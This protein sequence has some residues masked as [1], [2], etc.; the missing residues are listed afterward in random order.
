MIE[1]VVLKD[2]LMT[3]QE[4]RELLL[5]PTGLCCESL[6][7]PIGIECPGA[8]GIECPQPRLSWT[9]PNTP[10]GTAQTAYHIRVAGAPETLADGQGELWDSGWIE[11]TEATNVLYAGAPLRSLARC[12]WQVRIRDGRGAI[13]AWSEPSSWTMGIVALGDWQARWI[14]A[15]PGVPHTVARY[16]RNGRREEAQP[17]A[18]GD[19]TAADDCAAVYLRREIRCTQAVRRATLVVCGLGYGEF[20]IDGHKVGDHV[21]DPTFSDYNKRV[22]Y[23]VH[24]VTERFTPGS[25]ALAAILGNGFYNLVTPNLFQTEKAPWKT[26]P[27][28]LVQIVLEYADGSTATIITDSAWRQAGGPIVF[29]CVIGGETI[30][31]RRA[32]PGWLQPGF[33][34]TDWVP[35]LQVQAP[36]GRLAADL[37]PPMRVVERLAPLRITE[38]Q[39]G[40]YVVDFGRN[41]V[42]WV[43]LTTSGAAGAR[44][45]LDHN[46]HL[47]PQGTLDTAC[48]TSHTFGR[49]QH[50][51]CILA[52]SCRETFEPRF[53][54]HAFRYVEIRG[55]AQAPAAHDLVACRL[56]TDLAYTGSFRS[57]N[58]RLNF[59]HDAA[60]RTLADCTF[61]MPAA[62]AVREK[63][64]WNG[65]NTFCRDAYLY[66][67]DAHAL[68]RKNAL[69]NL[70]A[71]APNGQIPPIA[72]TNGWGYLDDEGQAEF[73]DDPWWGGS[74]AFGVQGVN[75][76]YGDL[77]LMVNAYEGC[78]RYVD[79]LTSTAIDGCLRWSLGDWCDLTYKW[80]EGPGLTPVALTS[81]ACYFALAKLTAHDAELLGKREDAATYSAL[82]DQIK[83]AFVRRFLSPHGARSLPP[84]SQTG[85]SLPLYLGLVPAEQEATMLAQLLASLDHAQGHLTTGFVGLMPTLYHLCATGHTDA[86][87]A[88]VTAP[89][90]S[91]WFWM[92]DGPDCTLAETI[93]PQMAPMHHH[94]FS[95]CIAGWLYR[96]LGGIRPDLARSES[97][98]AVPAA[99]F[100]IAP[101]LPADL[102]WVET[103]WCSPR[104][105]I[106]SNWYRR[107][108]GLRFE[109]EIPGNTLARVELPTPDAAAIQENG[110]PL[111]EA[112]GV[113]VVSEADGKVALLVGAGRYVFVVPKHRGIL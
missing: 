110:V 6:R 55:L 103:A 101:C 68:Y 44:I 69:D 20:F 26:P 96:C 35:A 54:Y 47:T 46:E 91:G 76:F 25:H 87:Y 109:I 74:L 31:A 57:A 5:S 92:L 19:C 34:D 88:A 86:A 43:C 58:D 104:G 93:F 89:E 39:P 77:P 18:A 97:H 108:D 30:D 21:L 63:I 14:A 36:L 15:R 84:G 94:Q 80:P 28:L 38:P 53:T 33:D 52:G 13:S 79:Y 23:R 4:P 45:T 105:L 67:F 2:P 70:D 98:A 50:Q 37:L 85:L 3:S 73:C 10:R 7:N 32:Q 24:D 78:R 22:Y 81:T 95:A 51:E 56:H 64:G 66:L 1:D 61:G 40:V 29:N 65:D 60:R 113:R 82:A 9:V 49:Y 59:L 100:V 62:E 12:F 107:E 8:L 11:S 83:A 102:A 41:L 111:A 16:F 106:V 72:P 42:G 99:D 71:Q 75:D 27:K 17:A 112:L 48:S 90:G